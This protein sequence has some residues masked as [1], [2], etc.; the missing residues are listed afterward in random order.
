MKHH[1]ALATLLAPVGLA[2]LPSFASAQISLDISGGIIGENVTLNLSGTVPAGEFVVATFSDTTGPLAVG[3]LLPGEPGFWDQDLSM[4]SYPGFLQNSNYTNPLGV[5][6]LSTLPASLLGVKVFSQAWTVPG[7]VSFL[8]LK[9]NVVTLIL[10]LHGAST[11]THLPPIAPHAYANTVRLLNGNAVV[12][13]GGSGLGGSGTG[14]AEVYD[15]KTSTFFTTANFPQ[16]RASSAAA[17]LN[18][19]RVL[20]CGGL[21]DLG[22]PTNTAEIFDPNTNSFSATGS[23]GL[24]R[25]L[26]TAVKL[27]DGR[28]LV[29]GGST[30]L[31]GA[32]PV[33]L[34]LSLISSATLSAEVY[35][36]ATG[37]WSA[38]TNMPTARTGHVAAALPDGR[39]LVAGGVQPGLFGIPSFLNS[40]TRYNPS[41]N[42]WNA[43]ASMG[44]TARAISS[45]T[46][47][48]DGR[49]MVSGGLTANILTLTANSVAEVSI[50]NNASNTWQ[51][52]PNLATSRYGH[53]LT[54]MPDGAVIAAGGVSGT[55]TT[56]T[57]PLTV[58]SVERFA[59]GAW[60]TVTPMLESRA[61]HGAVLTP[62][63][64]RIVMIGGANDLGAI[65]PATSE[66]YVP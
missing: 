55:V 66:L 63:G 37:T 9:S 61:V 51:N 22:V 30:A 46:T 17:L 29:C 41:T 53:S 23:M 7:P 18:D 58:S 48:N 64:K 26:H 3:S 49:V 20:V 42:S 43:T 31:S 16:P 33:A 28:V 24:A 19:G 8:D 45:V 39:V 47:L 32:D 54:T 2:V 12:I 35:N 21:N 57:T 56:T 1:L 27:A 59:G 6:D 52:G 14:S 5:L 10:G 36:P 60:S 44:G 13:G 50:Y 65:T 40:A 11:P 4:F 15:Y 34:L 25:M 62:D 38:A